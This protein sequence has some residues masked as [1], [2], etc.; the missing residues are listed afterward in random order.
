MNFTDI[1]YGY[2]WIATMA[3]NPNGRRGWLQA[4]S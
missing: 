4:I 2:A 1:P 3:A